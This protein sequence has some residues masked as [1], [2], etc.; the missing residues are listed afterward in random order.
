M[1]DMQTALR[2]RIVA[3]VGHNRVYWV[4]VPQ[5]A[6]LPY[7]RLQTVSDPPELDLDGETE[8]RETRVQADCF[9]ADYATARAQTKAIKDDA[10]A[11]ATVGGVIFGR[12]VVEGPRDLGEDIATTFIFQLSMDLLIWH[13]LA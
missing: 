9:G 4:K 8:A 6:V 10:T 1:P 3:A 12:T 13:R 5:G 2:T 11:P 7:V